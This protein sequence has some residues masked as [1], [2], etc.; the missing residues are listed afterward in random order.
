[1]GS[2]TDLIVR[3]N[4]TRHHDHVNSEEV[5]D[6]IRELALVSKDVAIVA[7]LNRLDYLTGTGTLGRKSVFST[8]GIR[9]A[10]RYVDRPINGPGSR[11]NKPLKHWA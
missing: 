11:C 1:V 7:I 6:L 3:K 10:S 2:H 9:K 8:F 4:K 5:T